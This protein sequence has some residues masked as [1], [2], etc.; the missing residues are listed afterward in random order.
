MASEGEPSLIPL[1]DFFPEISSFMIDESH[2]MGRIKEAYYNETGAKMLVNMDS[3][4]FCLGQPT[5]RREG[6]NHVHRIVYVSATPVI[7]WN[8]LIP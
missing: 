1:L 3:V 5:L 6:L 4:Y 2:D 8:K 7:E